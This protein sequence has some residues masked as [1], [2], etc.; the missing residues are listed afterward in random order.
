MPIMA[1]MSN[2]VMNVCVCVC[3]CEHQ[4]GPHYPLDKKAASQQFQ[5]I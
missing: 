3:V 1:I 4:R 2:V 5:C